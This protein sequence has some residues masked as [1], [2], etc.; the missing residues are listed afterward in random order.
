MNPLAKT[1][2][3]VIR[4]HNERDTFE[5]AQVGTRTDDV[6]FEMRPEHKEKRVYF[7]PKCFL[8]MVAVMALLA[9][10]VVLIYFYKDKESKH[11][12]RG[13]IQPDKIPEEECPD[14]SVILG[15]DVVI[16]CKLREPVPG[17]VHAIYE[18]LID[19]TTEDF[20]C[21]KSGDNMNV[22]CKAKGKAKCSSHRNI[23][24]RFFDSY[25]N[26][27][28]V[29]LIKKVKV[30][31]VVPDIFHVATIEQIY[32]TSISQSEFHLK[33][34]Y[35]KDCTSYQL[36][37]FGNDKNLA[38]TKSC[39]TTFSDEDGYTVACSA[40]VSSA[41]ILE[42]GNQSKLYCQLMHGT[43]V[44]KQKELA[45]PS[46]NDYAIQ[47]EKCNAN[48]T[49]L[50]DCEDISATME[51]CTQQCLVANECFSARVQELSNSSNPCPCALK[52]CRRSGEDHTIDTSGILSFDYLCPSAQ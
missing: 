7:L 5:E 30:N 21:N 9:G 2:R 20:T 11:E 42:H 35:R 32:N 18:N 52:W 44:E 27:K 17:E 37:F 10:V 38:D 48:T 15:E 34:E 16:R 45:L 33:C 25:A 24:L 50:F 40:T 14:V 13:D 8:L 6:S 26:D 51:S 28:K 4:Q 46:C 43:T 23:I 1:Q 3:E 47:N 29:L 12:F 31:I 41:V 22:N 49:E 39:T 36:G 19:A